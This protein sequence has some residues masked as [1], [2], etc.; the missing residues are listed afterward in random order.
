MTFELRFDYRYDVNG[1][2]DAPDRRAALEEAGRIW[3]SLIGDEFQDVPTGTTFTISNPSDASA[4][5]TIVLD[6][7]IDDLL[8]FVGSESL[9]GPLARGGASGFDA[10]GDVFNVRISSDFRGTGPVTNYEPWA[11]VLRFDPDKD[12]SFDLDDAVEGK[13]DFIS[14]AL[15]EIGHV[16]GIGNAVI[17]ETIGAGGAFD[18][19]NAL[20]A[21]GGDP[22]PLE[23]D[24]SHVV[25]GFAGDT[26][27][28]DPSS[29]QGQRLTPSPLDLAMLADI[30]YEV[31]GFTAQ[32]STPDIVTDGP[33][34]TVF[35]TILG[36]KIDALAGDDVVS[37]NAGD[38]TLS[39][40]NGDDTLFG[41]EGADH[42]FGNAGHDRVQGG[43]GDDSLSGNAG[44]DTLSGQEGQDVLDG[45]EGDDLLQGRNGNDTLTA[46]HGTD[47]L[48][49]GEGTDVF[50]VLAGAAQV[51]ISDFDLSSE[52][53]YLENSGFSSVTDAVAAITRPFSNVSRI[54]FL[55]SGTLVDVFHDSKYHY[56][57]DRVA[58]STWCDRW[59]G[60]RAG[61]R[62]GERYD[63][64]RG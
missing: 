26:V 32:G 44:D 8:I 1:F 10:S 19:P 43:E 25:D 6:A 55:G 49:G 21:N 14:T 18:G 34:E 46:Q 53:I 42:L 22:I 57:F 51:R 5:E 63:H 56:P 39:G 20:L 30:G 52:V 54:T 62:A 27:L 24:L 40:G 16:L 29:V 13:S 3:E 47:T 17:F 12:W 4:R 58:F 41:Q 64:R 50:H 7:P 33:D 11:G 35:G 15:H 9:G 38:D 61:R 28:M 59:R 31:E 60:H 45:G 48:F 23:A 37:G 36:D 2:F